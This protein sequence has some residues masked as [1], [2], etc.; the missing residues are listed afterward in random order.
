[1]A[2]SISA[3]NIFEILNT[4]VKKKTFEVFRMIYIQMPSYKLI[5]ADHAT[6]NDFIFSLGWALMFVCFITIRNRPKTIVFETP[7]KSPRSCSSRFPPESQDGQPAEP[8]GR[9]PPKKKKKHT[10]TSTHPPTHS[11]FLSLFPLSPVP[12]QTPTGTAVCSLKAFAG[13][14]AGTAQQESYDCHCC[15]VHPPTP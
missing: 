6:L 12:F 7:R 3:A 2:L 13:L 11:T 10:H 9:Q 14:P 4:R 15:I 5:R 1:M 8:A